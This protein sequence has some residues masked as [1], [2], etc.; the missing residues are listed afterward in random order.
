MEQEVVQ[1]HTTKQEHDQTR[2]LFPQALSQSNKDEK[3]MVA[4]PLTP[5]AGRESGPLMC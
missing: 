5:S 1:T 2:P 3:L 4:R